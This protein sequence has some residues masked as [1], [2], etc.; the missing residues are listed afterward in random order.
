VKPEFK[1]PD[2]RVDDWVAG[3]AAAAPAPKVKPARLT[4]D[5]DP[6]LHLRFKAACVARRTTMVDEV[7]AFI[8]KWVEQ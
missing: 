3:E 8:E 5:L 4:I 6:D 2:R 7:R 1:L